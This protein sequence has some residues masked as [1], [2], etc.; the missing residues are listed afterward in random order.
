MT[1]TTL[2]WLTLAA[3]AFLPI[4]VLSAATT[5]NLRQLSAEVL[6]N[7]LRVAPG[8]YR[9]RHDELQKLFS[10]SGCSS[11]DSQVPHEE[12]N[13]ICVLPG[14]SDSVILI[15]AHFDKV[16]R[17]HGVI[18]NWSGAALLPSIFQSLNVG[19]RRHTFVFV[20]FS[21]EEHG[22]VG[23]EYY[24][25]H[26]TS[27]EKHK[28]HA[29]VAID[30]LGLTPTKI[31]VSRSDKNLIRYLMNVSST[32]DLP[33]SGMNVDYVGDTD[34]HPFR[35]AKIPT[36]TFHSLTSET[37][38]VLHTER[39]TFSA[40]DQKAYVDSCHLITAYIAYLDEVVDREAAPAT[41]PAK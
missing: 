13:I 29:R 20:G 3:A 5:I 37:F 1:R 14:E 35:D 27:D 39:D 25:H 10:E 21:G 41:E 31:W 38:R 24:V 18:D 28:I 16:N 34:S 26:L 9:Q 4:T 19:K 8:S 30:T 15:G 17:G 40:V 22:M 12:P 32:L 11:R 23:S 6:I 36:I 7:R 33:L 2:K